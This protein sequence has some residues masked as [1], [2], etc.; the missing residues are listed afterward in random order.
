MEE[1]KIKILILTNYYQEGPSSRYRSFNYKKYF[2]KNN[3]EAEYLPLFRNGY[4][5]K[6]YSGKKISFFSKMVDILKRILYLIGNKNKYT[7]IIIETE[8]IK[9]LPYIIEEKLLKGISYS[10]DFDDNPKS[11]YTK[12]II[13]KRIYGNK[14]EKLCKKA[15][16]VTVGNNWYFEELKTNNLIYLP[17]VIDLDKYTR[18]KKIEEKKEIKIVWIGSKSTLKY[19]Q[20]IEK[21]L[22][23]LSKK[24]QIKLKI[25]GGKIE[26]K[27]IAL[28]YNEWSEDT[29]VDNILD[30]DIG[31]MP[32]YDTFWEKG[33]CGFK[34]IQY[35]ACGLPVVASPSPAN[36]EIIEN[37]KNGYICE[38]E[39]EWY[40][41]LEVLILN[42]N[43]RKKMGEEGRKKIE[44][45][46]SYQ[47]YGEKYAN[48]L[49]G[50]Y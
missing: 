17:T 28:E 31:I 18:M 50:R 37:K 14:I 48:I 1:T 23:N 49:R 9:Y 16:F 40:N 34:L 32:L 29:E 4:I 38:T 45:K 35:M 39:D 46:Y 20:I 26:L 25:I 2:E 5:E 43:L 21:P 19:L 8:L 27:D 30:G 10:L 13:L 41:Y 7:H 3:I 44:K 12:N 11:Q 15:K 6:L 33:K 24:Y 47:V 22:K 42:S 36:V